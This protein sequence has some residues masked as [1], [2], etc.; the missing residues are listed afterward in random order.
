MTDSSAPLHI[1]HTE[2]SLGW[3]G[4]ELRVLT[5]AEAFLKRGH[6]VEIWAAPGSNILDDAKRRGIP[7]R[8]LPIARRG[9]GAL[10]AVRRALSESQPDVVN[11]HSSTD[12]WLVALARL[13]LRRPPP[14]VRTRHIS[15]PVSRDVATR[16]LYC[17]ST[18]HIVTTG[19]S[20]RQELITRNRFPAE[21][22]TS[23]PTGI[24]I[25]RFISGDRLAARRHLRLP[26][27]APTIGVVATLR[28]WKGHRFLVEAFARL[29]DR[30]ARLLIVGDGPVRTDIA[31]RAEE[32][33]M[34]SRV[35]MP[36]NQREVLPWLQ[37]LDVF[38]LPSYANEGVPQAIMQAMAIGLPVISTPVGSISEIVRHEETGLLVAPRDV[39]ALREAIER[40]LSD[41]G[42]A[43]AMGE[44]ARMFVSQQFGIDRMCDKMEQVFRRVSHV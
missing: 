24:D 8:A 26:Q 44:R 1:V 30:R 12:S 35:M 9:I 6:R 7:C 13:L 31:R 17:R 32:L 41:P 27:T 3:G 19:E 23:I 37:A 2:S 36:G 42:T 22:I 16:W 10:H 14:M 39:V 11:T 29:Q 28:S 15:A 21:Q 25:S 43:K 18:S 20:L 4:Q 34:A 33:G 5:E 38:V 40:I